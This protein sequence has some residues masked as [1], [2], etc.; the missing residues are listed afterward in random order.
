[1]QDVT[2]EKIIELARTINGY[3][4]VKDIKEKHISPKHLAVLVKNGV[5]EKVNHGL[6]RLLDNEWEGYES[7]VEISKRI[8]KGVICCDSAFSKLVIV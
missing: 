6:Y 3:L 1:M 7:F 5:L 2:Q 4:R 8:S